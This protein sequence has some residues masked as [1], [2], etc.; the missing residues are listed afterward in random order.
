M[1]FLVPKIMY[2]SLRPDGANAVSQQ[3]NRNYAVA[4]A[5][6]AHLDVKVPVY[7]EQSSQWPLKT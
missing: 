1:R 5:F 6:L 4:A 2:D 3:M 7:V